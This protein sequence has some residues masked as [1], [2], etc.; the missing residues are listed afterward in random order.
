MAA[1]V[2]VDVDVHDPALYE[3]YKKAST[4]SAAGHGAR[5]I[6]RGGAVE[7]LEGDW[8]PKRL[9]VL[10]FESAEAARA[11]YRSDDYR[12][13]MAIRQRASTGSLVLVEGA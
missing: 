13:A 5:F 6:V 1:Y 2:I 9:V 7:V 10:E 8:H 12:E 3:E 11:W 4:R